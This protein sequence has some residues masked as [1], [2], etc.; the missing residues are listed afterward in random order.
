M[1]EPAT[2]PRS[3]RNLW[4]RVDSGAISANTRLFQSIV[5]ADCQV[6][7]VVKANGYG[8][9]AVQAAQAMLAGGAA[10]LGVAT[11]GEGLQLRAAGVNAPI[12]VLGAIPSADIA[13]ALAY[14]LT[15]AIGDRVT[16]DQVAAAA[17]SRGRVAR[18][19][20]QIDTGMHRLGLLPHEALPLL[21]ALAT[22][23]D[24]E[25]AG[26]FTHFACADE[27]W[28]PETHAQMAC[29]DMLVGALRAA[30]WRFPVVHA[31]S[32]AGALAFPA[33]RYDLVR[34]GI[35]LYGVAPSADL[36]LPVG[37]QPALTWATP[38]VRIVTLPA[39]SAVSYGG[40]YITPGP[41]RIATLAAGYAD[42]L[43]RAPAWRAVLIGGQ[44]APIVG[45]ICM[46]AAMVDITDIP[47]VRVGDEAVLLGSQGDASISADEIAAWLG[48]SAYEVL[49]SIA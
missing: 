18:C 24:I 7:G 41:R 42:G 2:Q 27:P 26:I 16:L 19:Q 49:T 40:R 47:D 11:I 43:R 48:T 31:A 32:S 44:R 46:D 9:G 28:R 34:P 39:G 23:R 1:I 33:A 20:L 22:A 10:Q 38:I 45:R 12:L 3:L 6:M 36:P 8:H 30:G 29:F 4:R 35:A 14:D 15:L 5:G 17:R 21:D 13:P 25:W 37:F